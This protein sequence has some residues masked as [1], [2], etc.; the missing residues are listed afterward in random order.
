MKYFIAA[1]I[2]AIVGFFAYVAAKPSEMSFARSIAINAAPEA[3][4][5]HVNSPRKMDAWNP[6]VKLDPKTQITY[7]GPEAGVGDAWSEGHGGRARIW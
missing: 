6:W 3:V 7:E 4:F 1:V 2:L 5:E